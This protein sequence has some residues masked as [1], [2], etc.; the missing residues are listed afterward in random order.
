[1]TDEVNVA[2]KT[3]QLLIDWQIASNS[4]II[5]SLYMEVSLKLGNKTVYEHVFPD[6]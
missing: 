5:D 6:K 3:A 4:P 2:N 1:M